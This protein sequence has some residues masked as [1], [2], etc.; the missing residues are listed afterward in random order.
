MLTSKIPRAKLLSSRIGGWRGLILDF[1]RDPIRFLKYLNQEYG[2]IVLVGEGDYSCLF[3][4]NST[5]THQ[6]LSDPATF[7]SYELESVPFPFSRSASLRRLTTA[8]ALMN[9]DKHRQQRRLMLPAF[10]GRR[11]QGYHDQIVAITASM[12]ENWTIGQRR[13]LFHDMDLLSIHFSLGVL[14]GMQPDRDGIRFGQLFED[15]MT[16]L[17]NPLAFLLPYD[18]PGMPFHQLLQHARRLEN[19]LGALLRARKEMG[20]DVGDAVSLLIAAQDED[21]IGLTDAELIGQT[22]ALFRG[23]SKTTASAL[24]WTLFFLDQHPAVATQVRQELADVLGGAVPDYTQLPHLPYLE[25]VIHESMRLLPP[26][27]WGIRYSATDFEMGGE[28]FGPGQ[29]VMYSAQ[30]AHRNPALFPEPDRF[31]PERWAEASAGPYDY[32]PFSAGPRLCLGGSFAMMAMKIALA[33]IL[34]AYDIKLIDGQ[35]VD[36]KGLIGSLPHQGIQVELQP[37]AGNRSASF[38]SGTVLD[39]Y[40]L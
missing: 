31:L 40:Q 21:G 10:H 28:R 22:V 19:E 25:A 36:R 9:G 32:F 5:Y 4:F 12:L 14:I 6:V 30:V 3:T 7:Y 35:R 23:G 37:W 17:F 18:V 11:L 13:D 8:L 33:M 20:T 24:T 38:L 16:E 15:T 34:Q 29:K 2:D 1:A 27:V 39:F 26:V